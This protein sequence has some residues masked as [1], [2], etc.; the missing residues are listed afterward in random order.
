MIARKSLY[1]FAK[2]HTTIHAG[3]ATSL[4]L[5]ASILSAPTRGESLDNHFP[6]IKANGG[7]TGLC[8]KSPNIDECR[9][10]IGDW[11]PKEIEVIR[12]Q[13]V[14]CTD[15]C[16]LDIY[17]FVRS[18]DGS[19]IVPQ[20]STKDYDG[21]SPSRGVEFRLFPVAIEILRYDGCAGCPLIKTSP[22]QVWARSGS[23]SIKLPLLG[24]G[25]FYLPRAFRR[26]ALAKSMTGSGIEITIDLGKSKENRTLSGTAIQE[27]ARMLTDLNYHQLP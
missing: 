17:G 14:Q 8:I 25:V 10:A 4:I 26:L 23:D 1:F 2:E 6:K 13:S 18:Y 24:Y 3:I 11:K 27:Y 22:R 20:V 5:A 15:T 16:P 12:S 7:L 9:I 21:G 19:R